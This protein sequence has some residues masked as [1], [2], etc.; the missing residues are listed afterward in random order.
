[1]WDVQTLKCL[2]LLRGFHHRGVC[3]LDFSG[4]CVSMRTDL[5]SQLLRFLTSQ[6]GCV[7]SACSV[8]D[9]ADGKSLVSVG[10][11]DE[12][13]IVVWDWKRGEKLATARYQK[14]QVQLSSTIQTL[15]V[16][17]QNLCFYYSTT[18][19]STC[20]YTNSYSPNV[21]RHRTVTPTIVLTWQF[22]YKILFDKFNQVTFLAKLVYVIL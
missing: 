18:A 6:P 2:S 9:A 19:T 21:I 5:R 7:F 8:P 15:L 17:L 3:A 13:S 4:T 10:V 20:A 1:M 14:L 12:H 11:D 22:V 16:I